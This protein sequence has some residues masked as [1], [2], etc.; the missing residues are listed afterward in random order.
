M[1][2]ST[3]NAGF[4]RQIINLPSKP[5]AVT[6][7][8]VVIP[9]GAAGTIAECGLVNRPVLNANYTGVGGPGNTSLALTSAVF[10]T[11]VSAK[12]D[13]DLANGEFYVDYINGKIHGRKATTG[14]T[15][16]ANY[17]SSQVLTN[18]SVTGGSLTVDPTTGGLKVLSVDAP[19]YE[20]GTDQTASIGRKHLS[21]ATYSAPIVIKSPALEASRL[22]K[23]TAGNLDSYRIEIAPGASTGQLYIQF[24]NATALP[25]EGS[26]PDL[27]APITVSH[28]TGTVSTKERDFGDEPVFFSLG[29]YVVI[30]TTQFTKTIAGAVANISVHA[31]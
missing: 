13:V 11:E 19:K 23:S 1:A 21:T 2:Q 14:T 31:S 30:S 18:T 24:Y 12:D 27:M 29:C 20:N 10:T 17:Y 28:T 16:T 22:I 26:V 4:L 9:A 15:G 3:P 25:P 8:A 5:L 6:A 7:E